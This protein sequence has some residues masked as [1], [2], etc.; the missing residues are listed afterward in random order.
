MTHLPVVSRNPMDM[1]KG[2]RCSTCHETW[3][4]EVTTLRAKLSAIRVILLNDG[5]SWT[6]ALDMI[7]AINEV[8]EE[9]K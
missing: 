5:R 1:G 4:C 6:R 8:I 3:P 7:K 2:T 9:E